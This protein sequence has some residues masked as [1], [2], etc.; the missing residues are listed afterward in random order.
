M[1]NDFQIIFFRG[2]HA[3]NIHLDKEKQF[4]FMSQK[5]FLVLSKNKVC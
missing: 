2:G 1:V 3:D 4:I 5:I